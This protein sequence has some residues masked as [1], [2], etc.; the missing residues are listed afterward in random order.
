M[1]EREKVLITCL[2]VCPVHIGS[3]VFMGPNVTLTEEDRMN[4]EWQ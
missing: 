4:G 2:D 1:T 3:N